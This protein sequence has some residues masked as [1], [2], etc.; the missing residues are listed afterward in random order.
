M[1][2]RRGAGNGS[3]ERAARLALMLYPRAFRRTLGED[4]VSLFVA[5]QT[6]RRRRDG[7]R[8][9][10]LWAL[11]TLIG[12][13][14]GGAMERISVRGKRWHM[15]DAITWGLRPSLRA[16]VRSPGFS[17]TAVATMAL[18]I[19]AS[20]AVF[21]L[22]WAI[23]LKP[24]PYADPAGLV[25]VED[26]SRSG[27]SANV[28][29]PELEDLQDVRSL[30][31][32]SGYV[33]A[34][35]VAMV[36]DEPVRIRAFRVAPDLFPVLGVRPALGR[37]FLESDQ[38]EAEGPVVILSDAFWRRRFGAD[39]GVVGQSLLMNDRAYLIIGVMPRDFA[40]PLHLPSDV[41]QPAIPWAGFWLDRN[42]RAVQAVARLAP[43]VSL[44]RARAEVSALA[45]RLATDHPATNDGW[46]M[47]L[48]PLMDQVLGDYR[49]AF[50]ALLGAVALLLLIG[51]VNIAGVF[52]ARNTARRHELAVRVALGAGRGRVMFEIMTESFILA[53][54]GGVL[55]SV[56]GFTGAQL[57]STFLPRFTP[58]LGEIRPEI[59]VV[60]FAV[61]ATGLTALLSGLLPLLG[62]ASVRPGDALRTARRNVAGDR[63][64]RLRA[65]LVVAEV[66]LSLFLLVG[67][68]V[69]VR[70]FTAMMHRDRGFE[71]R[72][73]LTLHVTLP[74]DARYDSAATRSAGFRA[75]LD[76]VRALPGVADAAEVT[77]FP[78][79]ALG[80]LA[81]PSVSAERDRPDLAI[82]SLMRTAS[83]TYFQ[84]MGIPLLSGRT[85]DDAD[86]SSRPMPVVVDARL[87]RRLW[88]GEEPIGR[89]LFLLGS[90]A[91]DDQGEAIVVGVTANVQSTTREWPEIYAPLARSASH[92][93][94]V[95]VRATADPEDLVEAVRSAIREVDSGILIEDM[96]TMERVLAER[97]ALQ[98]AQSFTVGLFAVLASALAC[99]GLYGLLSWMVGQ[100]LPEIGIRLA[101]GA[102]PAE[103]FM[104]VVREGLGLTVRGAALGMAA[105]WV[106]VPLVRH[107]VFGFDG[108]DPMTM[109]LS[110]VLLLAV[111][112]LACCIPARRATR[113]DPLAA[114]R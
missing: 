30:S 103:V 35:G 42:Q 17:V 95:V 97:F 78:Y 61:L 31:G 54:A 99:V 9:A 51:C 112:G 48:T 39:R 89:S 41:W 110:V 46:S 45:T 74:L 52:L 72:R 14:T 34:A 1:T 3:W 104:S 57:L 82:Q 36:D 106:V 67:G 69:M 33:Y 64:H 79:S 68:L 19:G 26:V 10:T 40:F 22:A 114:L 29:A 53:L 32:I 105:V 113:V 77:G 65:G 63:R 24:L 86:A 11:A 56:L 55:G 107:R 96:L 84:T 59:P 85:F 28:S 62:D 58:R 15:L 38:R 100:R 92:W 8:R 109:A 6:R 93:S 13:M 88:P 87:A 73:T 2:E 50:G 76:R 90:G 18:G 27:T 49:E 111:A 21:A 81:T 44:D 94:D 91:V 25:S 23:W 43:G 66:A 83:P 16:L 70:S 75:V 37:G 5:E 101:L 80:V 60:A 4:M 98:R 7:P 102:R 108:F 12:M 71:A 20:T 47:R